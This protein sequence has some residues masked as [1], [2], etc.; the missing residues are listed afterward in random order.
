MTYA[1]GVI[2]Y[3]I[4]IEVRKTTHTQQMIL[5]PSFVDPNTKN[6]V[7]PNLLARQLAEGSE[8]KP[9]R[10]RDVQETGIELDPVTNKIK[11]I[12][13]TNESYKAI[14]P[15]LATAEKYIHQA[16]TN[17]F[18]PTGEPVVVEMT[19]TDARRVQ[20][21]KTP[22]ALIRRILNART[23][24]GYPDK[25]VTSAD[26]LREQAQKAKASSSK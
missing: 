21:V 13:D 3:A 25:L 2:G 7:P 15:V 8:K 1:K 4:Y 12:K 23:D 19:N 16:I 10:F 14:K 11:Q 22:D 5:L 6:I 9:W 20:M 17:G 26:E 24:L 18:T